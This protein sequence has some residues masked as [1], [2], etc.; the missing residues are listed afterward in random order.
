[1]LQSGTVNPKTTETLSYV[2]FYYAIFAGH[3]DHRVLLYHLCP[4]F[5]PHPDSVPIPHSV[6]ISHSVL[7]HP[8]F[9]PHPKFHPQLSRNQNILVSGKCFLHTHYFQPC[10]H[11]MQSNYISYML[12]YK[13]HDGVVRQHTTEFMLKAAE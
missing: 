12:A 2:H 5:C 10:M 7:N 4:K 6:L 11:M 13:T 9:Y 1:M 3:Y 8:T